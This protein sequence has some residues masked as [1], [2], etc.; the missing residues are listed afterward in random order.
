M[1]L[2]SSGDI[3]NRFRRTVKVEV[4]PQWPT[5]YLPDSWAIPVDWGGPPNGVNEPQPDTS[6]YRAPSPGWLGG[7]AI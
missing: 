1:A 4:R 6:N 7:T 5:S 2:A 3:V